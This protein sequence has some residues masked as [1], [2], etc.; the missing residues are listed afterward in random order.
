VDQDAGVML[1]KEFGAWAFCKDR[2]TGDCFFYNGDTKELRLEDDPPDEVVAAIKG[3]APAPTAAPVPPAAPIQAPV[4]KDDRIGPCASLGSVA[5]GSLSCNESAPEDAPSASSG[6][7]IIK[8][9]GIWWCIDD[10]SMGEV[11]YNT[12]TKKLCASPPE[13]VLDAVVINVEPTVV[14]SDASFSVRAPS[15]SEPERPAR[16]R[17]PP[18][19]NPREVSE[20]MILRKLDQAMVQNLDPAGMRRQLCKVTHVHIQNKGLTSL[21]AM[22]PCSNLKV[23]YA[24]E[25]KICDISGLPRSLESLYLH[26]NDL[27]SMQGWSDALPNLKLLHLQRNCIDCLEG[28]QSSGRLE[29]LSLTCQRSLQGPLL[30][31]ASALRAISPGLRKLDISGNGISDISPLQVLRGLQSLTA[32]DNAIF[33]LT[34]VR[35]V[36]HASQLSVLSLHNN[37][38]TKQQRYRDDIVVESRTLRELDG[39][40][41]TDKEKMFLRQLAE[42]RKVAAQKKL[43]SSE[44]RRP[45]SLNRQPAGA[46]GGGYPAAAVLGRADRPPTAPRSRTAAVVHGGG[47]GGSRPSSR[48]DSRSDSVPRQ[49]EQG[50]RRAGSRGPRADSLPRF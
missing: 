15:S 5:Q 33:E 7:K 32:R 3:D 22:Q 27:W 10:P 28:L 38:V 4:A 31:D 34:S 39:K 20:A 42:R 44:H 36:L 49:L 43:R 8:E 46:G 30:L 17:P 25:N 2:G 14:T 45:A 18:P 6:M 48:A 24:Y 23:V 1:I 40:E 26:D 21:N 9:V 41:I 19:T 47:W 37:P 35:P 16:Q 29:E 12:E 50:V 11:W 13:E